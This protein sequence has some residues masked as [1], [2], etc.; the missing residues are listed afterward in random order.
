MLLQQ[1]HERR[2]YALAA[3]GLVEEALIA[4][5]ASV[6]H[7]REASTHSSSATMQEV[8][9][10]SYIGNIPLDT[11]DVD[12]FTFAVNPATDCA[13]SR[14]GSQ[15]DEHSQPIPSATGPI[16]GRSERATSPSAPAAQRPDAHRHIE[17]RRR[18]NGKS[19]P[20]ARDSA[21]HG[22]CAIPH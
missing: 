18:S 4:Q 8:A 3:L 13:S 5:C 22:R 9:K 19:R 14:S 15:I 2:A 17:H 12:R 16:H 10:V 11:I 1:A 20:N 6:T 7:N 21:G